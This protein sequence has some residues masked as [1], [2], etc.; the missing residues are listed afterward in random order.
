MVNISRPS[1]N[2]ENS[3]HTRE[4]P[5]VPRVCKCIR[6][7]KNLKQPFERWDMRAPLH[8]WRALTHDVAFCSQIFDVKGDL[9]QS[10]ASRK[11]ANSNGRL[12]E[13]AR[14]FR[15]FFPKFSR[16]DQV[17]HLSPAMWSY[18]HCQK[19]WEGYFF[20]Y[21]FSFFLSPSTGQMLNYTLNFFLLY[22]KIE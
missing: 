3:R 16:F 12:F 19:C 2:T 13:I 20:F 8:Y 1:A 6:G 18:N 5:L 14:L 21:L 10:T 4:K 17:T 22:H 9:T 11:G 7:I 15:Q